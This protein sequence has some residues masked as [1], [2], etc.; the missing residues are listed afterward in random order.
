MYEGDKTRGY[1]HIHRFAY[2]NGSLPIDREKPLKPNKGVFGYPKLN[3][4]LYHIECLNLRSG[5]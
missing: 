1:I 3:F 4:S 5:Y 2:T